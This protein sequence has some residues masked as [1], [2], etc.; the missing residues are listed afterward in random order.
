MAAIALDSGHGQIMT[1]F[2]QISENKRNI[3]SSQFFTTTE[4]SKRPAVVSV[5]KALRVTLYS[6]ISKTQAQEKLGNFLVRS[7]RS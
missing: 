4:C 6:S 5:R 1:H 7:I 3:N 2:R